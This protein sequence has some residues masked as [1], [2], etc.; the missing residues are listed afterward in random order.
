MLFVGLRGLAVRALLLVCMLFLLIDK[1]GY[2]STPTCVSVVCGIERFGCY[3]T[4]T[5]VSVVFWIE[6]FGC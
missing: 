5:R 6:S 4:P 1:F 2:F 3:I